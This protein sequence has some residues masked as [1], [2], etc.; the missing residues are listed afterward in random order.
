MLGQKEHRVLFKTTQYIVGDLKSC[1]LISF[2]VNFRSK[3]WIKKLI[4]PLRKDI[5]T[6]KNWKS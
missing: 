2:F 6:K 3:V 5:K 1:I 4:F